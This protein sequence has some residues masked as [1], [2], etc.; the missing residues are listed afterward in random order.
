[1]SRGLPILT[2]DEEIY[3]L[4]PA[5]VIA[6]VDKFARLAREGEAAS[7]FGYVSRRCDRHGYVH[8]DYPWCTI[9]DGSKHPKSTA[10]VHPVSRLRPPDLIIQDELHLITG[11]LG[12]TVGLFEVAI[13]ALTTWR[14]GS[15]ARARPLLVASTATARNAPEQ[16]RALYGRDV[17]IFPPQVLDAGGRSSPGKRRSRSSSPGDGTSG[18]APPGSGLPRRRSASARC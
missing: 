9:K 12:T 10:A 7:L 8:P 18:S 11:A 17:T 13:D 14:T 16:V 4:A 5:F 15:G 6:T 2:V 3:R 1:M